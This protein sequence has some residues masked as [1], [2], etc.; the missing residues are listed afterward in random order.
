MGRLNTFRIDYGGLPNKPTLDKVQKFCAEKLGLKRGEVIRIQ[1]SRALG[2]TF[3]TV[4][5]LN[6]ALKVCD[7]HGTCH[8]AMGSD[9]KKYPLTI[10]MEDGTV[11]VKLFDLSDDVS[12]TDITDFLEQ[13]G[14]VWSV[15]EEKTGDDQPF[16][17]I[18]TGVRIAKMVVNKN[19]GSWVTIKGELTQ[20]SYFGQR[21]TCRHC[22]D[23]LHVGV[24]CVQNKKLLVQKTFA[25]AVKQPVNPSKP[26]KL[27]PAKPTGKQP[28]LPKQ[29]EK[30]PMTPK[31]DAVEQ[32]SKPTN[33][34]GAEK[35]PVDQPEDEESIFLVPQTP[36]LPPS[37]SGLLENT[38][39]QQPPASG[40]AGRK[41]ANGKSDGNETDTS[42]SSRRS[43][44]GRPS[45]KQK[46]NE[47]EREEEEEEL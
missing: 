31:P 42:T 44:R 25:D 40:G 32:I 10:M 23:Y 7:E 8:E 20:I 27:T 35:M 33:G 21:Q 43:L 46:T 9:K 22:L 45:K 37:G 14:E 19:I 12:D 26:P 6:L 16:P 34:D 38:K 17:G 30:P 11:A 29:P 5:N 47:N 2:V 39:N 18:F 4:A 41:T 1:N 15:F 24:G 36:D 28:I 3:V 13:Y